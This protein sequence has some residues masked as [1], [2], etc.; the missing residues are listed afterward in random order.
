MVCMVCMVSSPLI[1]GRLSESLHGLHG[2]AWS[3]AWFAWSARLFHSVKG[4]NALIYMLHMNGRQV[5]TRTEL[6]ACSQK[7]MTDILMVTEKVALRG[8]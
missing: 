3:F 4:I 1:H 2:F 7:H 5:T 6:E 8:F